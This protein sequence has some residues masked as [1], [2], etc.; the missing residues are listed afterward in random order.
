MPLNYQ[1]IKDLIKAEGLRIVLVK[2]FPSPWGQAAKAMMEYKELSYTV[3]AL[4]ARQDND[5]IVRWA[6]V[7]SAPVVAWNHE[8]PINRWDDILL[9]LERL[10]PEPAL[11]PED[12]P[13]RA[14]LFGLGHAI[15]GELGFGWNRRLH[16]IQV[17]VEAGIEPGSFGDKYGYNKTDG[18]QAEQKSIDF[19]RHLAN[20][21]KEQIQAGS[22]FILGDSLTAL[23]F[24]WAAFSNLAK[25]QSAEDCPLDPEIRSRFERVSPAVL[26]AIDPIL[27]EHR[28]RIMRE[29]FRLPMEM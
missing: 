24:Y 16:G 10:A 17:G 6:G 22:T 18:E 7:N 14:Q 11:I 2:G 1:P 26:Q 4:E 5:L 19:L 9:L 28:D 12:L 3:G 21:L 13:T 23:D 27:I 29:H 25:I 8:A 20:I 15:C